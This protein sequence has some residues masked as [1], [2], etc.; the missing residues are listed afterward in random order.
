MSDDT[1][2]TPP[3][4]RIQVPRACQRCKTLRRGCNEYRPCRRC[5]DAGLGEQ[6]A[7]QSGPSAPIGGGRDPS[8]RLAELVPGQIIDHCVE[9]FFARLYPTIPILTRDHVLSLKGSSLVEAHA[10]LAAMCAQVLL[11]AEEPEN[12]LSEGVIRESN[13]TYGNMILESAV[14]THQSISRNVKPSLNQCLLAFFLYACHARLSHHSQAFLF[15]REA[16]TLFCLLRLDDMDVSTRALAGRLFWV[17][18]V[19]ERSHAIRYRRPITLQITSETPELEMGD[20]S[21]VGFWSLAALFRPIDTSFVA[22]LNQEIAATPPLHASLDYVETSVNTA[23]KADIHL[24]DT[25][26][27]NLRITQ[28]WLRV[29][30]WKLRLRLGHLSESATQHSL[31]FQYPL[32]VAKDL[33]LSTRD[34]PLESIKVHGVGLTEKLYDVVSAVVDVLARVPVNPS[35]PQGLAMGTSP[36]DD[37]AYIRGLMAQLPGGTNIYEPLLVNHIQQALPSPGPSIAQSSPTG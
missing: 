12:L 28:L 18:L 7:A 37:L 20:P 16:T 33:T 2:S 15:L 8:Q 9:R 14:A 25:Q 24:H 5:V 29:I 19:S 32:E 1:R 23:L 36:Q 11:Q 31:T 26:K 21:L 4:K 34:L 10:V 22:L 35:S 13:A 30:I 3:A 17:L 27:A 6:C